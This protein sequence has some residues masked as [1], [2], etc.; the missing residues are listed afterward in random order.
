[1]AIIK[2]TGHTEF[3]SECLGRYVADRYAYNHWRY[4]RT[5]EALCESPIEARLLAAMWFMQI[6]VFFEDERY[7]MLEVNSPS[8]GAAGVERIRPQEEMEHWIQTREEGACLIPQ[9]MIMGYRAD[10]LLLAK[11]HA[12][13]DLSRVVVECDG[14]DYHERTKEQAA[15]DRRRDREMTAAGYRV[16]RFTGSEIFR[17]ALGCVEEISKYL[18]AEEYRTR[19]EW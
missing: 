19:P 3:F 14:H 9:A 18:M 16:F 2:I 4:E 8:Q 11:F 5:V 17:D 1:M 15:Y 6:P 7:T 10:F 13:S 12:R